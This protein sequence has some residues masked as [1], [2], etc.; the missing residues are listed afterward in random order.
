MGEAPPEAVHDYLFEPIGLVGRAD[1]LRHDVR[2][3]IALARGC[4]CRCWAMPARLLN[5]C[6][7]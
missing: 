3:A 4:W 2:A 7:P 6:V 1:P 5:W